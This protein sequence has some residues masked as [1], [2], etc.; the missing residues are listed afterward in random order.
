MKLNKDVFAKFISNNF[1]HC[2]DEDEFPYELKHADLS[3]YVR[4][5][6]NALRRITNQ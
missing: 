2:I 5:K 1:Y 4:K 3:W 6:I